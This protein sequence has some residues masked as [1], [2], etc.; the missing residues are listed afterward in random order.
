VLC[1]PPLSELA[2]PLIYSGQGGLEAEMDNLIVANLSNRTTITRDLRL[3]SAHFI[4]KMHVHKQITDF[5]SGSPG[6]DSC[7]R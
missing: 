6:D 5:L 2:K 4:P 7:G 3:G 1:T